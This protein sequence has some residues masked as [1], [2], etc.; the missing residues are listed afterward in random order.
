MTKKR[1]SYFCSSGSLQHYKLHNSFIISVQLPGLNQK[2]INTRN[3]FFSS[4][5]CRYMCLE[6]LSVSL[7]MTI[8]ETMDPRVSVIDACN[9]IKKYSWSYK[10]QWVYIVLKFDFKRWRSIFKPILK[11]SIVSSLSS[12]FNDFLFHPS[13]T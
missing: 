7:V 11:E 6:F 9:R 8:I 13:S 5:F 4:Y 12:S 2:L 1:G 3:K 10:H